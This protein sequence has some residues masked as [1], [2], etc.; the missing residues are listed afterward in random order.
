MEQPTNPPEDINF[1]QCENPLCQNSFE[2]D[3]EPR[4]CAD[5]FCWM[6]NILMWY[7]VDAMS[8]ATVLD[9]EKTRTVGLVESVGGKYKI[10]LMP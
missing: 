5:C 1:V 2:Y 9:N 6:D 8:K 4:F 7:A 10:H 3:G